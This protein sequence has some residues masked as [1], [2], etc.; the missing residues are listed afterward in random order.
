MTEKTEIALPRK[1]FTVE[2]WVGM[3]TLF[4]MGCFAYL[5][6]NIAGMKITRSGYYQ[7]TAQF[8]NISGL[9]KGAPVEI[10]GV[11]IG[12]VD[13]VEL[14]GT[15]ALVMMQ[16]RNGVALRDDDIAQIR[17]K[18]IIGDKYIKISPGGSETK[19]GANGSIRDTE[20]AVEFEEIIGKFIHGMDK[21]GKEDGR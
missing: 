18:G 8:T 10:A 16:I 13:N 6:I 12:D 21:G 17:T 4:G 19:V 11:Q 9:K 14:D 5:S 3:F 1:S 2:F 20:S 7:V 15:D